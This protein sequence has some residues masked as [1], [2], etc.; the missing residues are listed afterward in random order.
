MYKT[1]D[2]PNSFCWDYIIII[3]CE[4]YDSM[5]IKVTINAIC[6]KLGYNYYLHK[7]ID[8]WMCNQFKTVVIH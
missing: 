5:K 1:N 7:L 6:I 8:N 3:N 2:H 4:N